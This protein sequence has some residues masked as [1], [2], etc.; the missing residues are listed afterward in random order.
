MNHLIP[1]IK[2]TN[3]RTQKKDCGSEK[4]NWIGKNK[5]A[6]DGVDYNMT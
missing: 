4:S 5:A 2:I 3:V 6:L 1:N